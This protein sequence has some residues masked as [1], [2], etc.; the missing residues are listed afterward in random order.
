MLNEQQLPPKQELIERR[1]KASK[2]YRELVE[3]IDKRK[4][5]IRRLKYEIAEH[6]EIIKN[7]Y[8]EMDWCDKENMIVDIGLGTYYVQ[9]HGY[10]PDFVRR[11]S[12]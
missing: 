3:E 2:R 9:E 5:Y 12:R 4:K 11:F 6:E 8:L 10:D 1:K 7:F